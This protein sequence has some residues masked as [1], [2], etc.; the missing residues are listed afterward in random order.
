[1]E[2]LMKTPMV[3]TFE[4][5]SVETVYRIYN[6]KSGEYIEVGPDADGIDLVEVRCYTDD[7]KVG[8]R[9]MGT[10]LEMKLVAEAILKCCG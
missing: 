1:M 4:K 5:Y 7:G 2:A 9:I 6:D 8:N 3:E 10:P